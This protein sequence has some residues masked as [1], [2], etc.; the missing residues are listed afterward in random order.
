MRRIVFG[1]AGSI[2]VPAPR[3]TPRRAMGRRTRDI[4]IARR[5]RRG[6]LRQTPDCPS[7]GRNPTKSHCPARGRLRFLLP[8][9]SSRHL[10]MIMKI[11]LP[12]LALLCSLIALPSAS[13]QAADEPE[14]ELGKHMEKMSGPFRK[15]RRQAAD[16]TKNA[17]SLAQIAIIRQN[18][19]ASLKFEPAMK[20]EIPAAKQAKFVADYQKGMKTML[21]TITKVEAALKANN[22]T[23]AVK[24]LGTMADAQKQG[25]KQFKKKE[26]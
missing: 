10:P 19:E 24:L 8:A 4:K 15:L 7:G 3:N 23:E 5:P 22:N 9:F 12:L 20:A 16:A 11:R 6:R 14:T 21:E 18:A 25:H 1:A 2:G 26:K 17:D 13:V